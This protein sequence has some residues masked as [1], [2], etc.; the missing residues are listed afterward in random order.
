MHKIVKLEAKRLEKRLAQH[1]IDIILTEKSLGDYLDGVGF[2]PVHG[3]RP[4]KRRIGRGLKTNVAKGTLKGEYT[5]GDAIS[6]DA[7][8]DGT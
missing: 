4:L 7:Y 8:D 6:T 1:H 3:D 2:D 5:D